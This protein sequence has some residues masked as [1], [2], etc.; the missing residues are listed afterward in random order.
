MAASGIEAASTNERDG[1][2]RATYFPGHIANSLHEP[3]EPV[4][5]MQ[6]LEDW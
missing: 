4:R 2:I 3:N 5:H 1:G 6:L